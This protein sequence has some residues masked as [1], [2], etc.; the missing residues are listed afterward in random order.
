VARGISSSAEI[1]APLIA[2]ASLSIS[3]QVSTKHCSICLG[4]A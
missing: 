1:G 3:R 2:L 4:P